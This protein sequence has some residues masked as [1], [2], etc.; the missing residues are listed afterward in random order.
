MRVRQLTLIILA[1]VVFDIRQFSIAA[2][3]PGS[4]DSS[5]L[6][7]REDNQL[8]FG[9]G[10]SSPA[11]QELRVSTWNVKKFEDPRAYDDLELLA[12]RQDIVFIQEAMHSSEIQNNLELGIPALSWSFHKSFC[13]RNIATGV[14]TASRFYQE[15]PQT[16][17]SPG[18]E[19]I[20]FTPKVSGISV[21]S[22]YKKQILIINTHA[23]NFNSGSAFERQIDQIIRAISTTDFPVI[24]GGDFN[25]WSESRLSYLRSRAASVG[26]ELIFPKTDPRNLKLD[27]ILIRGFQYSDVKV[28]DDIISSDHFPVSATLRLN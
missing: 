12:S 15:Y 4:T 13:Q 19:P 18:T 25:T 16:L 20:S 11:I 17:V 24:W 23:L 10:K 22:V 27:H 5:N 6:C 2:V 1:L 26:L 28:H 7:G 3:N 14:L 21:V 9:D 8:S